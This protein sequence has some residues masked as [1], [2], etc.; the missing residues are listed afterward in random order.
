VKPG[1]NGGNVVKSRFFWFKLLVFA[2]ATMQFA[3]AQTDV[4]LNAYGAFNDV[5]STTVNY[6]AEYFHP[7]NA[8]GGMLEVR[9]IHSPWVGFEAT[10][11]L[12]RANQRYSFLT[13][14][15]VSPSGDG[16]DFFS[17]SA[18]AHEIAGDWIVTN[19]LTKSLR[20]FAL[21][22]AGV[23][24]TVPSGGPSYT[25]SSTTVAYIYGAGVDWQRFRHL[26]VRAQYRGD[27][28]KAPQIDTQFPSSNFFIHTAEPM[29]G[30]Y[31]RF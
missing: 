12:N 31:Y 22:G 18:F 17:V 9:H 3:F 25:Q 29:V 28:H 14:G 11:S 24:I 5:G 19:H 15:P 16:I 13:F 10:Y 20:L 7:A 21:A 4:G 8:A 1:T 26:G 6:Y 2:S 23:Q 27:I 30:V